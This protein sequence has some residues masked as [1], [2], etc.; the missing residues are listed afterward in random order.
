MS[1]HNIS[2]EIR[3]GEFPSEWKAIYVPSL[4]GHM[5]AGGAAVPTNGDEGFGK[6]CI[7][8]LIGG[9]DHTNTIYANIGTGASANFNAFAPDTD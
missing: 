1:A 9:T 6:G 8:F 5:L 7:F 2:S 3:D 4:G